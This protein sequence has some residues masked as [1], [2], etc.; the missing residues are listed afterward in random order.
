MVL[1]I[2]L[3]VGS[4]LAIT[5]SSV[6]MLKKSK[7]KKTA[8]KEA[9]LSKFMDILNLNYIIVIE[10]KSSLNVYDQ[11]F[12][13]KQFNSTLV[14]G[15]LEAIRTFGIDLSGSGDQSQTIKLEYKDSKI[16]M[17]DYK[18]FRL[19]F[20]M[21]D[22]PSQYFYDLID[23][24]SVEIE[25]HYGIYLED[26]K[27]NLVPFEGIEDLLKKYLGISLLYP[28]KLESTGKK[29]I[30]IEKDLINRAMSIMKKNRSEY[31]FITHLMKE[32]VFNPKEIEIF[33]SLIEKGIFKPMI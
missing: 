8:R 33:F 5:V 1:I 12:T 3:L 2:S 26:F 18:N 9:T 30:P 27:G 10:K 14:S 31:F 13:D 32:K 25:H 20:I 28:L 15:F 17:S 22:L 29:I 6:V 11:A 16:L 21:K 19:I 24:L 23:K 4:G 7:K